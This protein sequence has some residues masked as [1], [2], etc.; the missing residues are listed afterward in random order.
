MR[1]EHDNTAFA[2]TQALNVDLSAWIEKIIARGSN[3][4][5]SFCVPVSRSQV[6]R[7]GHCLQSISQMQLASGEWYDATV[8]LDPAG[9]PL[10]DLLC[11]HDCEPPEPPQPSKEQTQEQRWLDELRAARDSNRWPE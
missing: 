4:G 2:F 6:L 8:T 9:E 5:E 10:A 3:N 7:C 11:P 1:H